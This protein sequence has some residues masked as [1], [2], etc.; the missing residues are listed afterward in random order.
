MRRVING[1]ALA[2]V[3]WIAIL[4]SWVIILKVVTFMFPLGLMCLVFGIV[5]LWVKA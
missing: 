3:A 1:I 4:V 5:A 2:S